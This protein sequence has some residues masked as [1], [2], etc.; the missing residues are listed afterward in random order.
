[1]I[2]DR[3]QNKFSFASFE[4]DEDEID[5]KQ[6]YNDLVADVKSMMAKV[7]KA[8]DENF[9]GFLWEPVQNDFT[10]E[11][12]EDNHKYIDM[13]LGD[14]EEE[15]GTEIMQSIC[16]LRNRYKNYFDYI[17]AL[18][19]WQRYYDFV[20]DTYGSFDFFAEMVEQGNISF[21]LKRKPKLKNAKKNRHLLE[22]NVPISRINREDGLTDEQIKEL[23]EELPEQLEIYEDYYEYI[24]QLAKFNKKEEQ[25]MERES[26][27][28]NYRKTSAIG[29]PEANAIMDY[30]SGNISQDNYGISRNRPL[31]DDIV[32]F[33]EY[34]GYDE[35]LKR[36][37][38][39]LRKEIKMDPDYKILCEY[40]QD[41]DTFEVYSALASAGYD[42]KGMVDSSTMDRKA[43]KLIQKAAPTMMEDLSPKKRK[44]ME[45]RRKKKDKELT[46]RLYANEVVR[47]T[48]TKNRI[49]F[50]AEEN[51]MSFTLKDI[52]N[53]DGVM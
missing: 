37:L 20:E 45:K 32:A 15:N 22:I 35:D 43:V 53:P 13:G 52:M 33:H 3:D 9:P 17:D 2:F 21:P 14:V 50:D 49:S 12:F 30:L 42:V 23:G 19:I 41:R 25:R 7:Y 44:K 36:D 29:T 6:H 16:R 27:V 39:G 47:N 8:P 10:D 46:E 26:R 40:G 38:M 18:D 11:G 34:D 4:L 31:A 1:M 48:L 24:T 5:P 28:R 51:M